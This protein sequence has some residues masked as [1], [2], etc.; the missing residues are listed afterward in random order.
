MTDEEIE[1]GLCNLSTIDLTDEASYDSCGRLIPPRGMEIIQ[2]TLDYINR[3]KK[4]KQELREA[5]DFE[6]KLVDI[7]R[8]DTAK[9]ILHEVEMHSI[10]RL[11]A[12]GY[13]EYTISELALNEISDKYGARQ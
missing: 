11:R 10:C 1:K 13:K 2:A 6:R 5:Y 4:E 9:E 7:E 8:K 3:L 12:D